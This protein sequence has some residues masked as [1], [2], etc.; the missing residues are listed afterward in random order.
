MRALSISWPKL[1]GSLLLVQSAGFILS[2]GDFLWYRLAPGQGPMAAWEFWRLVAA[3]LFP[4]L[5]YCVYRGHDW[6]RLTVIAVGFCLA[7]LIVWRISEALMH[8]ASAH[9]KSTGTRSL[10][11]WQIAEIADTFGVGLSQFLA[12][13]AFVI[14]VLCHRDVAA[15]FHSATT[16]RSNHAMERTA[17]RR[18]P[19]I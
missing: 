19:Y 16:E 6:A 4:F 7:A 5:S 14:C 8:Y 3:L 17:D 15:A 2:Q 13:L 10:G 18:S 12:P 9:D 11:L 1:V